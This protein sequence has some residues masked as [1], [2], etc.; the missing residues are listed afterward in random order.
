MTAPFS[1]M[2]SRTASRSKSRLNSNGLLVEFSEDGARDSPP[3]ASASMTGAGVGDRSP[4][5]LQFAVDSGDLLVALVARDQAVGALL[6]D[7]FALAFEPRDLFG[8][9]RARQ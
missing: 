4:R 6:Q 2:I 7:A 5:R 8:S 1:I 9:R 3:D